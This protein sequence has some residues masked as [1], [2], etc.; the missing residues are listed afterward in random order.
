M[1]KNILKT[2]V[3]ILV[4]IIIIL[5][6]LFK[7]FDINKYKPTIE[8]EMSK[9][10]NQSVKI[11][12]MFLDFSFSDGVLLKLQNMKMSGSI[13]DQMRNELMIKEIVLTISVKEY[14]ANKRIVI[15]EISLND[16]TVEIIKTAIKEAAVKQEVQNSNNKP[17]ESVKSDKEVK[18]K[19]SNED[20]SSAVMVEAMN[21]KNGNIYYRDESVKPYFELNIENIG[22]KIRDFA[23]NKEFDYELALSLISDEDNISLKGKASVDNLS[24][25]VSISNTNLKT[26]IT[27]ISVKEL[28]KVL[29]VI[30]DIGLDRILQGLF[31]MNLKTA[32]IGANGLEKL[33]LSG[34][35][36]DGKIS[37]SN[38]EYP[39]DNID[40]RFSLTE[41]DL[42]IDQ[43]FMYFASGSIN[44]KADIADYLNKQEYSAD[45][46]VEDVN[47]SEVIG[48]Y[49]A[50][51]KTDGRMFGNF[52]GSGQ[53]FDIEAIKSNF[54]GQGHFN[55]DKGKILDVNL[56][57]I[58]LEK[59]S[60]IPNLA[61]KIE[62]SL[63]EADKEKLKAKDTEFDEFMFDAQVQEGV[64]TARNAHVG[65]SDIVILAGAKCDFDGNLSVRSD[66]YI[67][68]DLSRIMMQTVSELSLLRDNDRIRIPMK[69]YEGKIDRFIIYPD[70]EEIGKVLFKEKGKTE[71]RKVIFGALGIEEENTDQKDQ[72]G[73]NADSNNLEIQSDPQQQE[74]K[75]EK[76]PESIIIDNVLDM[77]FK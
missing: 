41:K 14:L 5:I 75:Q 32:E 39:I 31:T 45:L 22:F 35:I 49:I 21:I 62:E 52:K 37:L 72:S 9:A 13:A 76:S 40:M 30:E 10:S 15:N 3:F 28:K 60:I 67:K 11:G 2:I 48:K 26:N 20:Y 25:K 51:I 54:Q 43:V 24:S 64:A 58:I 1:I 77:I 36:I 56:L 33:D 63:S 74:N 19:S 29:P 71:L 68:E 66:L 55:I 59:I 46:G 34:E 12:D 4:I 70:I 38:I 8:Y 44:I 69:T 27:T 6:Y 65:T 73:Q 53:G 17:T 50:D 16:P 7:T 47:V 57:K 18:N 23:F 61:E 42:K